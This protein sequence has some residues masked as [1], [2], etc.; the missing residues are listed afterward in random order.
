MRG[1]GEFEMN[2]NNY[3]VYMHVNKTNGKKYIGITKNKPEERWQNGYGYKKQVFYNAIQKYGWDNFEHIILFENI[4]EDEASKKEIEMISKYK[5]NDKRYGYNIS[6]GGENGHNDLWND[7]EYRL[8]QVQER[9]T[10]WNNEEFRKHHAERLRLAMAKNSYKK[11]I[12]KSTKER[13]ENGCFDEVHC[14]PIICLE[15]GEVYKSITE[16]SKITNIGR[17]DIGKCCLGKEMTAKGYHWQYYSENLENEEN[18]IKLINEL[19]NGQGIR[20][21]CIETNAVYN[22][23]REAS[24]DIGIDNSSIGKV[25]KGKQKTAGGFHWKIA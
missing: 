5:S 2:E 6:C 16:A 10:R 25:I 15:T 19:G 20:V 24:I 1:Q 8:R 3:C 23:I 18:R 17:C 14:K 9:K 7:E 4:S 11:A 21:Q 12:A 13:W 22:S